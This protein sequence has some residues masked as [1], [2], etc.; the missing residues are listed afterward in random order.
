M[1]VSLA[2]ESCV[3]KLLSPEEAPKRPR[4]DLATGPSPSRARGWV[5]DG[6]PPALP[7][8]RA[9]LGPCSGHAH[10]LS[11]LTREPQAVGAVPGICWLLGGGDEGA[12]AVQASGPLP[13]PFPHRHHRG[14]GHKDGARDPTRQGGPRWGT[15][16]AAGLQQG[17]ASQGQLCS[18]WAGAPGAGARRGCLLLVS[19]LLSKA[20]LKL[21]IPARWYPRPREMQP[22]LSCA[23]I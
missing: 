4:A 8:S 19:W 1:T 22:C 2:F 9:L 5:R 6:C 23:S 12:S 11:R 10:K 3:P 16:P 20:A 7:S 18:T 15:R 17:Q 14:D 21:C 13:R